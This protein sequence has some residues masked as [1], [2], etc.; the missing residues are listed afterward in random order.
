MA[1]LP[2]YAYQ[3]VDKHAAPTPATS[4]FVRAAIKAV[5]VAVL[6]VTLFIILRTCMISY[7]TLSV[8]VQWKDASLC[9]PW[10]GEIEA[11]NAKR[12]ENDRLLSE[13]LQRLKQ[14]GPRLRSDIARRDPKANSTHFGSC[15]VVG[16]ST[17]LYTGPRLFA[18]EIDAHDAVIRLPP[19][20]SLMFYRDRQVPF[21]G[22][23]ATVEVH[24]EGNKTNW[25]TAPGTHGLCGVH[26]NTSVLLMPS[27]KSK[28]TLA[29][30][31]QG[32]NADQALIEWMSFVHPKIA[33]AMYELQDALNQAVT[34]P[35]SVLNFTEEWLVTY[36][37]CRLLFAFVCRFWLC[38]CVRRASAFLCARRLLPARC[39]SLQMCGRIHV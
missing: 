11:Q 24:F 14:F 27:A 28:T 8:S 33:A 6:L 29:K 21:R 31:R 7:P 1:I 16:E 10:C 18:E 38:A 15:A 5:G 12:I 35:G 32:C 22:K 13:A 23:K 34:F 9:G 39:F 37:V 17:S 4:R 30:L 19:V 36:S 26:T 3:P 2:Q 25:L 20:E